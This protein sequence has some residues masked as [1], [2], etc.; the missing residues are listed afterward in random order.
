[1]LL[2]EAYAFTLVGLAGFSDI[3]DFAE[4]EVRLA[5][6]APRCSTGW[7]GIVDLPSFLTTL[8]LPGFRGLEVAVLGCGTI[9]IVGCVPAL[10]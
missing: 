7:V 5:A 4:S 2:L 3:D 6:Q 10:V 9:A 8:L 1:M